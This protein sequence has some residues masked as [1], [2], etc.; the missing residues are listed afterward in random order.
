[1]GRMLLLAMAAAFSFAQTESERASAHRDF[2]SFAFAGPWPDLDGDGLEEVATIVRERIVSFQGEWIRGGE[3][4]LEIRSGATL[5]VLSARPLSRSCVETRD[6]SVVAG[7]GDR[8]DPA[9]V[10]GDPYALHVH[11]GPTMELVATLPGCIDVVG[12]IPDE[13]GDGKVELVADRYRVDDLDYRPVIVRSSSRQIDS[14][15]FDALPLP[16][17]SIG[18]VDGDGRID[19]TPKWPPLGESVFV[20]GATGKVLGTLPRPVPWLDTEGLGVAQDVDRDGRRDFYISRRFGHDDFNSDAKSTLALHSG[21]TGQLLAEW[22]PGCSFLDPI[23]LPDRDSDGL[24]DLVVA[25]LDIGEEV[26]G[27]DSEA[28]YRTRFT[29]LFLLS[30]KDLGV[31]ESEPLPFRAY[32]VGFSMLAISKADGGADLL[33]VLEDGTEFVRWSGADGTFQPIR[34][35]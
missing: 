19:L 15:R 27:L 23:V 25:G 12:T 34:L 31:L 33:M 24:R 2:D 11:S 30:G 18:D 8:G 17:T 22:K 13:D 3:L 29:R 6:P 28:P 1:M 5:R 14:G 35:P 7:W 10:H 20:S 4:S 9:L 26:L 16:A 32:A 21:A